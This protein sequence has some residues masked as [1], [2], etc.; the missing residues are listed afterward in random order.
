MK[1]DKNNIDALFRKRLGNKEMMPSGTE[2]LINPGDKK[3]FCLPK[4]QNHLIKAFQ[5]LKNNMLLSFVVTSGIV[6][7]FWLLFMLEPDDKVGNTLPDEDATYFEKPLVLPFNDTSSKE[8]SNEME[9][10]DS[11]EK[12]KI[13][14]TE[15]PI[16]TQAVNLNMNPDTINRDLP[17]KIATPTT[18]DSVQ[19]HIPNDTIIYQSLTEIVPNDSAK[20]RK[21]TNP[22]I[23]MPIDSINNTPDVEDQ[24]KNRKVK[25]LR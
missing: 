14:E 22:E 9:L 6:G 23:N 17:K 8:S 12:T 13:K 25:R 15:L 3:E 21:L 18:T 7:T 1:S 11:H 10:T 2:F 20:N 16:K 24:K 4:S 5:I 19:L